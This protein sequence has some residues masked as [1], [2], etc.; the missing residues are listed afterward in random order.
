MSL[1]PCKG[2][3]ALLDVLGF[4]ELIARESRKKELEHYFRAIDQATNKIE[5]LQYVL[6]SDTIVISAPSGSCEDLLAILKACSYAM[7]YLLKEGLAI[8]GG[9]S[10]G[11]YYRSRSEKGVVIAGPAFVEAYHFEK[12]QN[13]VGIALA[14]S[15]LRKVS[16]LA[17]RCRLPRQ[18]RRS[19]LQ[20]FDDRQEWVMTVQPCHSIPWHGIKAQER[21]T[22][23]GI[24]VVPLAPSWEYRAIS[25][26][27]LNILQYL[28]RQQLLAG[29]PVAQAK[30][31]EPIRWIGDLA[32]RWGDF[33]HRLR[34]SH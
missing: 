12:A 26:N 21:T 6:F 24:A 8:R 33:V 18:I 19:E 25:E 15:V 2:Y 14:P 31:D 34:L 27:L 22:L 7:H 32:K 13:W 1:S 11:S 29:N 3:I 5:R 30:Y 10:Y 17:E 16:D 28:Q 9:V 23:D 4:S 20:R